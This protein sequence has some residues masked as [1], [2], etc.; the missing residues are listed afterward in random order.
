MLPFF[1]IVGALAGVDCS[2]S[3][4]QCRDQC[5]FGYEA[6]EYD[7]PISCTCAAAGVLEGDISFNPNTIASLLAVCLFLGYRIIFLDTVYHYIF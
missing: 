4:E 6:N 2:F 7:C 1:F 5:P 3:V